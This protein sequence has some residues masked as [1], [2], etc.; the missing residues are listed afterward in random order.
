MTREEEIHLMSTTK[1]RHEDY[2]KRWLNNP[3]YRAK[4]ARMA[5]A[6]IEQRK[7]LETMR[8]LNK[9]MREIADLLKELP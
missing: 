2:A 1:E 3:D 7:L 8:E 6:S 4:I 9:E 5:E